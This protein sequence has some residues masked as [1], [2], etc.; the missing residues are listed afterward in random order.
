MDT[1]DPD[2]VVDIASQ[3]ADGAPVDWSSARERVVE[4]SRGAI[5]QLRV[6]AEIARLHR[7]L[8]GD[9][10]PETPA[11]PEAPADGV[12]WGPLLVREKLGSGAFGDVFRAWDAS[13]QREVALKLLRASAGGAADAVV[14]EGQRLARVSHPNVMAVYGAQRVGTQVGIWGELLRGKTLAELIADEGPLSADEALLAGESICRALSAVHRVG[15]LHR[16][17]KA[18][19]V[20]REKGGR[21]VL[22]DFG[23]G[24]ELDA[25][26]A[27]PRELAGTPLYLAPELFARGSASVQSDLYSL[28]V[29]LFFLVTGTF[30]VTGASLDDIARAHREERR[31]R[32]QDLRPELPRQFVR[33]VER[34]LDPDP[35]KRYRSAGDMQT[36]LA[37][38][39]HGD[40]ARIE[41]G[42][43]VAPVPVV[44]ACAAV[45]LIV[46][47]AAWAAWR[48]VP[49]APPVPARLAIVP[50]PAQ[51][52]DI[53]DN[54][55]NLAISP[56]GRSVV[57]RSPGSSTGGPLMLRPIDRLDAKPLA[58]I[59]N[60]RGPFFSADGRSVGFFDRHDLKKIALTG[61]PAVLICRI[62]DFPRGASWSDDDTIVFATNGETT[63]LWRVPASGGKPVPI[64]TPDPSQNETDHLFPSVLPH[65]R[66]V[67]F[68]ISQRNPDDRETYRVAVLDYQTGRYHL[69]IPNASQAEYVAPPPGSRDPGYLLYAAGGGLHIVGFDLDDLKLVGASAPVAEPLQMAVNGAA[70]YAVAGTGTLVYLAG[71]REPPRSLVWV[72][73]NGTA[74]RIDAPER[75]YAVPRISPD[76]RRVVVEV[77]AQENDLWIW[78]FARPGLDRFTFGAAHDLSA[79][80]SPDSRRVLFASDRAGQFNIYAQNTDGKRSVAQI[81]TAANAHPTSIG[82]DG[83]IVFNQFHKGQSGISRLTS[84][85]PV[86]SLIDGPVDELAGQISPDG[87]YIAYQSNE[88]GSFEVYVAPYPNVKETRWQISTEGGTFPMWARSGNELFFLDGALFMTAVPVTTSADQ[89]SKST[90]AK[91]FDARIYTSDG[92]RAYDVS[93]NGS[94]FLMVKDNRAPEILVFVNWFEDVRSKL[95]QAPR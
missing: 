55:R 19:N 46:A 9:S 41:T 75:S 33:V 91:L 51:S 67:L 81:T 32:L 50:P 31:S 4:N 29:L 21:L 74:E 79:V 76:G 64:T 24:R 37:R 40:D 14:V 13:L 89:F 11:A 60:G 8:V 57:Y 42:G 28:G 95:G 80:W 15:M 30:P 83:S 73:R 26:A 3:V 86:E 34:A 78:D 18:Q 22:M 87:R 52:L 17:V 39:A 85:A 48:P 49:P 10:S 23:L 94:R 54:D 65:H 7:G 38:A 45:A 2:D 47:A 61:E 77:R 35:A 70:N 63:G 72:N 93:P 69:L 62:E 53:Q 43:R 66:G 5:E 90:P 92:G 82:R 68:T 36:A 84:G 27:T 25:A 56:D 44:L 6:I 88:S 71:E 12:P 16:D 20:F 1:P 59:T 58:G